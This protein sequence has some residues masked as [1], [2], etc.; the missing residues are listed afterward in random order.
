[1]PMHDW[2]KVFPEIF[3]ALHLGWTVTLSTALNRTLPPTHYAL[4][5]KPSPDEQNRIA[6]RHVSKCW[7]RLRA[8]D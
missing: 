1:M 4:I 2:T 8:G 3:A 5:E 7:N 6:L